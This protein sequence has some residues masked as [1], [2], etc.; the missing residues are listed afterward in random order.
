MTLSPLYFVPDSLACTNSTS[1]LLHLTV[2]QIYKKPSAV[3]IR[4]L[5]LLDSWMSMQSRLINAIAVE[6]TSKRKRKSRD[7][8]MRWLRGLQRELAGER[9]KMD[10]IGI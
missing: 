2:Q 8:M 5:Q 10:G 3:A 7:Q 6:G 9:W 4:A 1:F